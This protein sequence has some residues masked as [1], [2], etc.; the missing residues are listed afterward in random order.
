MTQY[1]LVMINSDFFN[2]IDLLLQKCKA[3]RN[4]IYYFAALLHNLFRDNV[5][6]GKNGQLL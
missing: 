5:E 6:L 3:F 4:D 1:N 2:I